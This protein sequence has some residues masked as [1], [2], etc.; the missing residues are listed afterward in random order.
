MRNSTIVRIG[1]VAVL[2]SLLSVPALAQWQIP[3]PS[4]GLMPNPNKGVAL[5]GK[6]CAGCHGPDLKGTDKGP[7]FLHR[8]YEPSHHSDVS[9]QLA[10]KNGVQAH[11]WN[12]GNMLPIPDLTP[13][14][15]AHIT[16]YIRAQQRRA[17]IR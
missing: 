15:V 7:P 17:G 16:A 5:Y 2:A 1:C 12:F 13:D 3:R 14:D 4:P 6:S 10:V 9:F 8:V 11:H